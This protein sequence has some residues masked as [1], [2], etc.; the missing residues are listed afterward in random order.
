MTTSKIRNVILTDDTLTVELVDERSLSIP[1]GWYPR[2][3]N[4]NASE[5][6]NWEISGGGYGIHWPDLDED[7]GA[8]GLLLGKKSNESPASFQMWLDSRQKQ[9]KRSLRRQ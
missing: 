5:R 3:A 7:L 1:I 9:I 8:E 6:V 4:G 2:L